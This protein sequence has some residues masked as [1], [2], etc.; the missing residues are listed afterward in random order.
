MITQIR[1]RNFKVI[2]DVTLNLSPFTML[3]GEN[4][5]GKST[6]LQ[7]M[8]FLCSLVSRDIDEYLRDR[9][10]TFA[11]LQS[12]LG[13]LDDA[14]KF[15]VLA[16]VGNAN[17]SW[18][19]SLRNEQQQWV[20]QELIQ[21]VQ[22][23]EVLLSCGHGADT[24]AEFS[25]FNLQSSGMKLMSSWIEH[26]LLANL[27]FILLESCSFELLSPDKM[28]G[29]SRGNAR[30]I[31][32]SG[33]KIAAFIHSMDASWRNKLNTTVSELLGYDV[34]ISTEL[35]EQ[36]GWVDMFIEEQWPQKT[37]RVKK[38]CVSD[39][40]LR[41]IG[42]CTILLQPHV[43]ENMG[44][45]I[46]TGGI[47]HGLVL[48]DEIEDGINPELA[49]SLIEGFQKIAEQDRRQFIITSHSPVMVNYAAPENI[50]F[51]WRNSDGIVQAQPMFE[52]DLMKKTLEFLNPGEAWLNYSKSE[53]L[54]RFAKA[55]TCNES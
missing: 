48:L 32:M 13:N 14:I 7:A 44:F 16:R 40:L 6:V 42:L 5:C 18:N 1:I 52:T 20:V 35:K 28:R 54:E 38:H 29:E 9:H 45:Y 50:I 3:I 8:D 11:D 24:P 37:T 41:I 22:T 33:E 21:D 10:W 25:R 47:P 19:I 15:D 36:S 12:Q 31:G 43:A 26:K 46:P 49:Q 51:M 53:I 30:N 39:G 55:E 34:S 27:R 23:G 17:I 2:T 4:S